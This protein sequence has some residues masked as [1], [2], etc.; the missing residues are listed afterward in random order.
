MGAL[1]LASVKVRKV[2]GGN[3]VHSREM[4]LHQSQLNEVF[5]VSAVVAG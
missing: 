4:Q 5:L 3:K 1:Q 2:S